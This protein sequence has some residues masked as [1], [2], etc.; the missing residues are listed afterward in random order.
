[1]IGL[2]PRCYHML[3]VKWIY[4][5]ITIIILINTNSSLSITKKITILPLGRY[6]MLLLENCVSQNK[7]HS[8]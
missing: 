2:P 1:M 7:G 4:W 5:K 8:C 3:F 6:I